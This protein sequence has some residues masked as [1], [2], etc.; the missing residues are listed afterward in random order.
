M[1]N[2]YHNIQGDLVR[3]EMTSDYDT[4]ESREQIDRDLDFQ[5]HECVM[6]ECKFIFLGCN[7]KFKAPNNK[8]DMR[9]CVEFKHKNL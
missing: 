4:P 8:K 5:M 3:Y 6:Y 9:K 2:Y 1:T 7:R